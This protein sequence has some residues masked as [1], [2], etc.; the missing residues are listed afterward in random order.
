[1]K[2]K[3]LVREVELK[4]EIQRGDRMKKELEGLRKELEETRKNKEVS[5][6]TE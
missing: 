6:N 4:A 1:M 3:L 2:D 5:A